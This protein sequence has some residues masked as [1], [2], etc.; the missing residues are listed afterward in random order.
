[1]L[2]GK[3]IG[4]WKEMYVFYQEFLTKWV[5]TL[6]S[7]T[8]WGFVIILSISSYFSYETMTQG[9]TFLVSETITGQ[10]WVDLLK[11]VISTFFTLMGTMVSLLMVMR[12]AGSYMQQKNGGSN[13]EVH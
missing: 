8:V 11:S 3:A 6:G 5:A 7:V 13:D 9:Y 1:M 12:K 2:K 10:E 4:S